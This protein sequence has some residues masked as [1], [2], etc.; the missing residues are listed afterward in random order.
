VPLNARKAGKFPNLFTILASI[1]KTILH[2]L[3]VTKEISFFP[4]PKIQHIIFLLSMSN[5]IYL[6]LILL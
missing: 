2:S 5:Q 3:Y 1:E 6:F 4:V